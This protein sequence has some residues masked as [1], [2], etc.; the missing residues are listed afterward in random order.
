MEVKGAFIA[1]NEKKHFD[2]NKFRGED[3]RK[4]NYCR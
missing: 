1:S 2:F 3:K 4:M